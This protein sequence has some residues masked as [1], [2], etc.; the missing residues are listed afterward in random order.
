MKRIYSIYD[1]LAK[2]FGPL[3]LMENDDVACRSVALFLRTQSTVSDSPSYYALYCLGEFDEAPTLDVT[4]KP[5]VGFVPE[6]ISEISALVPSHPV[7][8]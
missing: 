5:V 6:L 3:L 1:K 2:R 4:V 8:V 7:K